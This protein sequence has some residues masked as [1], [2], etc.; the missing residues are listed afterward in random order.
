M[1]LDA[2]CVLGNQ[3]VLLRGINDDVETVLE[4]NRGLLRAGC[5]PYYIL[6]CDMAQGI[7]HF[8][9]PLKRG[10]EIIE[11]L[12]GRIGGMGIP[13][14]VVDLPGG[15]GK[16]ELAPNPIVESADHALGRVVTFRNH[17]GQHFPFVDVDSDPSQP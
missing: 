6:Q 17:R 11:E 13:D 14:F 1:L 10:V 8:R 5:R 3:M 9:T 12:R 4:L 7:T 2:G 15:G 16:V